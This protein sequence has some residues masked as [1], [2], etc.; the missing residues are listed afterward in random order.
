MSFG[1]EPA[2]GVH[3]QFA[4]ELDAAVL[5]EVQRLARSAE[6]EALQREQDHGREAVVAGHRSNA[7]AVDAGH[8]LTAELVALVLRYRKTLVTGQKVSVRG[9]LGARLNSTNKNKRPT[10]PRQQ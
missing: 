10:T 3:R 7:R 9:E 4:A 6:A 2:G 5:D 8:R 1:Q